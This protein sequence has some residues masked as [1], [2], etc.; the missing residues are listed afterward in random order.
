MF[1]GVVMS[2]ISSS[3]RRPALNAACSGVNGDSP[4]A[5]RSALTKEG[6][7]AVTGF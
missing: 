3:I 2:I 1:Y 5:I 7:E 4:A 6:Q